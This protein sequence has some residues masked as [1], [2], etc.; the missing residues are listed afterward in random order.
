MFVTVTIQNYAYKW[1]GENDSVT[2]HVTYMSLSCDVK[3][4]HTKSSKL[5][6]RLVYTS[7]L[8]LILLALMVYI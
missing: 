2:G 5:S 4:Q 6:Y 1:T 3:D 7:C 8:V